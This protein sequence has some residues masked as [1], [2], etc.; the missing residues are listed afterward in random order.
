MILI[1]VF[2]ILGVYVNVNVL[3]VSVCRRRGGRGEG[4]AAQS[5]TEVVLWGKVSQSSPQ[6]TQAHTVHN[7][8]L[9]RILVGG[10][11]DSSQPPIPPPPICEAGNN[12][13]QQES[14]QPFIA[15]VVYSAV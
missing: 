4:A 6:H 1:Y 12:T 2:D 9:L 8:S 15:W 14:H 13:T 7:H 10:G 5:S 3:Y 11:G